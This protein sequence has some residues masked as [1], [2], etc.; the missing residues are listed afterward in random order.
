[1]A[2]SRRGRRALEHDCQRLAPPR[3]IPFRADAVQRLVECG[4]RIV[5]TRRARAADVIQTGQATSA[6][7]AG[8]LPDPPGLPDL[9]VLQG[10]L[11]APRHRHIPLAD[12]SLCNI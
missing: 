8:D 9:P 7:Y 4:I 1:M 6:E 3:G 11:S 10:Q 12:M 5:E 2:S